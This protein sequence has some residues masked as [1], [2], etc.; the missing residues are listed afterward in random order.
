[1]RVSSPLDY[2]RCVAVII[3]TEQDITTQGQVT[4]AHIY[5][6]SSIIFV[7]VLVLN[8]AITS[9]Y[10][11]FP[12]CSS[13]FVCYWP[14]RFHEISRHYE[15]VNLSATAWWRHQMETFSPLLSPCE[16]N[17]SPV[18]STHKGQ[19]RGALMFSLICAWTNGIANNWNDCDFRHSLTHYDVTAMEGSKQ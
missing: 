10:C 11:W 12:G 3:Q 9:A 7:N 16:G 8:G 6:N 14:S 2:G 18:K 15:H 5:T 4:Y 19:W 17:Q 1:M 13:K